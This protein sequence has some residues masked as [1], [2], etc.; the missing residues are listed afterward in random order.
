MLT[1]SQYKKLLRYRDENVPFDKI[2]GE[3]EAFFF[4]KNYIIKYHPV[5]S[6]GSYDEIV[7]CA[8]TNPGREALEEYERDMRE[9]RAK[10]ETDRIKEKS[11]RSANRFDTLT[12]GLISAVAAGIVV[13]YWPFIIGFFM[14]FFQ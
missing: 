12:F 6:D 9:K 1:E 14:N 13:Y 7:M 4:R 8:I 3:P 11:Q 5:K 10:E 2:H